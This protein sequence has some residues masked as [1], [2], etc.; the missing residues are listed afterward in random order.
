MTLL[1]LGPGVEFDRIRS[2]ARALGARGTALGDDCALVPMGDTFLALSCDLTV[3]GVHYR[4]EWLT[5][6]E[7]GWRAATAA[8]SDLAADGAET[9]G[10]LVALGMP[11]EADDESVAFMEGVGDAVEAAGGTVLGGDLSTAPAWACDVTAVGRASNPVTRAGA[12]NGDGIWVTGSLGGARAAVRAWEAGREPGGDARQLFARPEAR[13]GAGRWLAAAGAHAMLDLSDGLAGDARHLAAASRVGI[14]I[15]LGLVPVAPCAAREAVVA[16]EAPAHFAATGGEDYE[17]LV[18]MPE[19]F[20]A[21]GA[22]DFLAATGVPLV[23]VGLVGGVPGV[24]FLD[25]GRPTSLEG[26]DHFR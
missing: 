22:R 23:R 17:L 5:P 4:R 14:D 9:I 25:E 19:G 7:A 6:A 12:R 10:V 18:A 8:L 11:A 20:G 15:D 13:I 16:G 2:I 1:D 3:E 26:F 24:R 21:E